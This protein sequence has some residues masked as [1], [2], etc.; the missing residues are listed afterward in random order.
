M[1]PGRLPGAAPFGGE[2]TLSSR[3][4]FDEPGST[5]MVQLLYRTGPP[6]QDYCTL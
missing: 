5:F 1:Y 2:L 3:G 4:L 6:P